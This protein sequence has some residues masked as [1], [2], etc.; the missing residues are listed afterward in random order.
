[1]DTKDQWRVAGNV[2]DKNIESLFDELRGYD[3]VQSMIVMCVLFQCQKFP[4][5]RHSSRVSRFHLL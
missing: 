2:I 4:C 3:T 5:F 1:M